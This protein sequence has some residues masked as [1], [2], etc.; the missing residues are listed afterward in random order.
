L[1]CAIQTPIDQLARTMR[2][3][4]SLA[5]SAAQ[6]LAPTRVPSPLVVMSSRTDLLS[7]ILRKAEGLKTLLQG[8]KPLPGEEITSVPLPIPPLQ[9]P[10]A[11]S[12]LSN[13][14]SSLP[15]ELLDHCASAMMES[16]EVAHRNYE[17]AYR[18][19]YSS[20]QPIQDQR[21][22]KLQQI[23]QAH[24]RA[25][26]HLIHNHLIS[27]SQRATRASSEVRNSAGSKLRARFRQVWDRICVMDF[28][29][30]SFSRNMFHSL[31]SASS[32]MHIHLILKGRTLLVRQKCR[33]VKSKFGL[34][35]SVLD[36]L[37]MC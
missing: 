23:V 7:Q 25:F 32:L 9:L 3:F 11:D 13:F 15:A 6:P 18:A 1:L 33:N 19:L 34:D 26:I 28:S 20:T 21:A 5:S 14:K 12:I 22:H 35:N 37:P 10:S 16:A 29:L 2:G 36:Q 4:K 17:T 27:A 8:H 24:H 30:T 31:N